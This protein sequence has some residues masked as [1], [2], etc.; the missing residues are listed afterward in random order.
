MTIYVCRPQSKES[1]RQQEQGAY[2]PAP[3]CTSVK[4]TSGRGPLFGGIGGVINCYCQ[5]CP[6]LRVVPSSEILG[7][8]FYVG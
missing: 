8:S 5:D 6:F 7:A 2:G 4:G 3:V 1:S